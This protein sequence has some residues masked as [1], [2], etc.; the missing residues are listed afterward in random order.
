MNARLART[1]LLLAVLAGT[2]LGVSAGA[3]PAVS[4]PAAKGAPH[5]DAASTAQLYTLVNAHRTA[6]GLRTL[7]VHKGLADIARNWSLYMATNDVFK[8]NDALFTKA[9]H[10]ALG[11]ATLGENI[12][13]NGSV[14][15]AHAALLNSPH[16]LYNI[17]LPAFAVA[18]FAV[19]VDDAGRYWVTEDFGSAPRSA[20]PA[21]TVAK[22]KA[23]PVRHVTRTATPVRSAPKAAPKRVAVPA[24]AAKAATGAVKAVPAFQAVPRPAPRADAPAVTATTATTHTDAHGALSWFA[25]ILF[26]IVVVSFARMRA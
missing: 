8:H 9:S 12:A 19:V 4:V 23:K 11:M 5:Y 14:E 22:P 26:A 15:G 17:E 20:A 24:K 18:G 16:H 1:S 13:Y 25:A 2:L 21:R 6:K 3:A 7:T 10:R